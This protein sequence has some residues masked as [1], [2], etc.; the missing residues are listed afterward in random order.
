MKKVQLRDVADAAGVT[1]MTVSRFFSDPGLVSRKTCEAIEEAIDR[2]GYVR[3]GFATHMA[4]RSA[5]IL[6]AI[7]P[8][9]EHPYAADVFRGV[10]DVAREAGAALMVFETMF[11]AARQD[12]A[13]ASALSWRPTGI[14]HLGG[15]LSASARRKVDASGCR[16]VE[17]WELPET[18]VDVAIGVPN[19][20]LA[21]DLTSALRRAGYNRVVF[22]LRRSGHRVED[23]RIAGYLEAMAEDRTDVLEVPADFSSL[24]AGEQLLRKATA[25]RP[26]PDAV[27]FAGDLLAT[28]AI[29]SSGDVG[30]RIPD[31]VAVAGMGGYDIGAHLR[32]RLT[33]AHIPSRAIGE[34]AARLALE[35]RRGE[36]R[37]EIG[38][39]LLERS[40][41]R[42][43]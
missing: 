16:F 18:P 40:S 2:L 24:D 39:D 32:P 5:P 38:F 4:G 15:G 12:I 19:R 17:A 11:D 7:V 34:A 42:L 8:T 36:V 6:A 35:S 14:I 30:V 23:E 21:R 41:A 3:D 9:L 37:F 20:R 31:D 28:G 13:V 27:L 26:R 10:S 43:A 33:T 22:A 25:L 29:L 1:T